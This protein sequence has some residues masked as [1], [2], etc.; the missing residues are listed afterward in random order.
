MRASL[1]FVVFL[2]ASFVIPVRSEDGKAS[3]FRSLKNFRNPA[4]HEIQ[5]RQSSVCT[6]LLEEIQS[7]QFIQ[8]TTLLGDGTSLDIDQVSQFCDTDHCVPLVK[9]VFNDIKSCTP[10][11]NTTV[12]IKYNYSA[13]FAQSSDLL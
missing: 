3:L 13:C 7:P 8:C 11:D 10:G 6:R 12:R 9:R 1:A 2:A 5:K 4:H